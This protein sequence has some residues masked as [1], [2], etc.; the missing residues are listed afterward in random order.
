[1]N[2]TTHWASL[3]RLRQY[4]DINVVEKRVVRNKKQNVW[5]S[6]GVA[7]GIDLALEFIA[8]IDGDEIAGKV[9]FWSEY[10]PL[11]KRYSN[12]SSQHPQSPQYLKSNL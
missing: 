1:M 7:S 11:N 12:I 6:S 2:A 10:F 5:T 8:Y 9:Q 3:N 4:K